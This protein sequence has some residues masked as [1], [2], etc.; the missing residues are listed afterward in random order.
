MK[1]K[2][3]KINPNIWKEYPIRISGQEPSK[4]HKEQTVLVQSKEGGFVTRNC[5]KCGSSETLPAKVFFSLN[6]LVACPECKRPMRETKEDL[7]GRNYG[8]VCDKC[9]IGIKLADL[10]P[11]YKDI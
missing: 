2:E 5:W 3:Y 11:H 7:D 10:L 4:C 6:L 9:E 8:Y 1:V